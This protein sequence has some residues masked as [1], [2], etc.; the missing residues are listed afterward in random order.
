MA[1]IVDGKDEKLY[2]KQA[3]QYYCALKPALKSVRI[4]SQISDK[5]A[6][7]ELFGYAKRRLDGESTHVILIID[8]DAPLRDKGE[9]KDFEKYFNAYLKAK[10]N[11]LTPSQKT[12]YGWMERLTLIVN[13]PC[14]EYWFLLHFAKGNVTAFY[15][16]YEPGLKAAVRKLKRLE[17]YEKAEDYYNKKPDIFTRLGGLDGLKRARSNS[18][19]K[20]RDGSILNQQKFD[21]DTCRERSVSEMALMF[22]EFDKL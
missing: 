18:F 10:E 6:V 3:K 22:D 20:K 17:D 2:I 8:F 16:A 21:L 9:Y 14:L 19:C 15:D 1:I 12:A 11:K 13:N 5:K 7:K 4:E